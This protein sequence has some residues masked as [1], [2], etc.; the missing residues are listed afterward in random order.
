MTGDPWRALDILRVAHTHL[1]R[2][3]AEQQEHGTQLLD[4][5]L[6]EL[7]ALIQEGRDDEVA[8]VFAQIDI[9]TLRWLTS[10]A[11]RE[12]ARMGWEPDEVD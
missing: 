12:L 3:E 6:E 1:G 5:V 9:D 2:D 10:Q 8:D 11:V 7:T 4:R